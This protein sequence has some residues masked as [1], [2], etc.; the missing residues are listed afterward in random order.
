MKLIKLTLLTACMIALTGC[1]YFSNGFDF[2]EIDD[3]IEGKKLVAKRMFSND[4]KTL[5]SE[6]K[7]Q[8]NP[9]NK[10]ISFQL[11]TFNSVDKKDD[12][13]LTG[14][15]FILTDKKLPQGKIRLGANEAMNLDSVIG[16]EIGSYK[17]ILNWNISSSV[18]QINWMSLI[19]EKH[20]TIDEINALR[21]TAPFLSDFNNKIEILN[22]NKQKLAT[23]EKDIANSTV[24]TDE[25]EAKF[26]ADKLNAYKNELNIEYLE[27]EITELKISHSEKIKQHDALMLKLD[28]YTNR[29][30]E[31]FLKITENNESQ[32]ETFKNLKK[33]TDKETFAKNLAETSEKGET[34]IMLLNNDHKKFIEIAKGSTSDYSFINKLGSPL[35]IQF[36]SRNSEMTLSIDFS[37]KKLKKLL[38]S[39]Q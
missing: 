18:A 22:N 29:L 10:K 33:I 12:I 32:H 14:A 1:D 23:F 27:K 39:C 20:Q 37:D 2:N 11:S 7:F 35:S 38:D 36:K 26:I 5:L 30:G 31:A 21:K 3:K 24:T 4:E 28:S 19:F 25:D 13:K 8:C 15:E 34:I 9:I 16:L 17:N 6:V